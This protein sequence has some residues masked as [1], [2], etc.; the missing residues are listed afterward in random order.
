MANQEPQ[1]LRW[2]KKLQEVAQS[3]RYYANR[4]GDE[5]HSE[6]YAIVQRVAAEIMAHAANADVETVEALFAEQAGHATPK[7][8]VRAVVFRNAGHSGDHILLV[9]ERADG[10]WTVP[11]GWADVN[12]SASEAAAREAYEESGYRVRPLR[13][14]A[15]YD[16]SQ[17]DHPPHAFHIYKAFF[18]CELVDGT[19]TTSYEITAV[20]FFAQDDLPPLSVGRITA[21]QIARF[22]ELKEQPESATDFD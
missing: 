13:L 22:F 11:G 3:G 8:D 2:A 6:R 14:L 18:L 16:R 4:E 17:H 1:W 5:F 10:R 21:A 7:I 15:L 19:P 9:R 12:E 20:G